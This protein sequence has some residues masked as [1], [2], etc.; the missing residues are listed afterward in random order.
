MPPKKST[1]RNWSTAY[2]STWFR[3]TSEFRWRRR[4]LRV[5]QQMRNS[6]TRPSIS[7]HQV[8]SL[9]LAYVEK[10]RRLIAFRYILMRKSTPTRMWTLIVRIPIQIISS[11]TDESATRWKSA[12]AEDQPSLHLPEP[13]PFVPTDFELCTRYG[14]YESGLYKVKRVKL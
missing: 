14:H 4:L 3:K 11:V 12:K 10:E 8:C 6:G 5:W 7:F 1:N 9:I 2:L 13:N